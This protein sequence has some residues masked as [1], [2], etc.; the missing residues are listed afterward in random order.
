MKIAY[1]CAVIVCAGLSLRPATLAAQDT[2]QERVSF[3]AG[4]SSATLKGSIKGDKTIDYRLG[5]KAG[6]TMSVTLKTN[7]GANYFNVLPPGSDAAIAIGADTGNAW[8]GTLPVDGDYTVR[9]F[10]MRA[11]ARRNEAAT[12]T[13][14]VGIDSPAGE[15]RANDAKVAGT[16][17]HA[18]GTVPCSVGTD[19]KGSAQCSFG[20]VRGA[21]GNAEVHLASVG[22][23][24]TLHPDKVETVLVFAGNS[25]TARD[26]KQRVTAEKVGDEWSIGINEF[27]F[28]SISESVIS[29]G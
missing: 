19:P 6:Q 26:P 28:Y 8:T 23:D 9:V 25:V 15:A 27:H 21:L 16:R 3:K 20:V 10:L 13:L 22:Y 17:Y 7:N 12:Y 14:A 18:T 11:A 1:A 29:G 2:R 5:A 24:V 4:A